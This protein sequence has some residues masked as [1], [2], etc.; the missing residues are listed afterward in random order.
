MVC[1]HA[2]QEGETLALDGSPTLKD[3]ARA[4][5]VSE[6]TASR[7]L[8]LKPGTVPISPETQ[9]RVRQ[10]AS[11][12]GYRTNRLA[13]SLSRA[14]TDTLGV[15]LPFDA[16][17][18]G[19]PYNSLILA[20]VG[21]AATAR[22]FALALY[23]AGPGTRDNY[24]DAL[25]DGRVDG[26]LVV[27][28][29]VLTDA[30]VA[31]LEGERFPLILVGHRLSASRVS[32]V[33]ADD[34]GA[35]AALT[36]HLIELGHRRIVHLY[37]A[38]GHPTQQRRLG[39]VDAMV[40]AGLLRDDSVVEDTVG[41]NPDRLDHGEL[42]RALLDRPE[43]PTAIFAWNDVV[44]ASVLQCA[45]ELGV[46]V[47]RRLSVVGFNDTIV[48]QLTSPPLTTMHQPLFE[49]GQ[50]AANALVDQIEARR[51]GRDEAPIQRILPG[52]IIARASCAPPGETT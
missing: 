10:V 19:K 42:V 23:Y 24:A 38:G 46:A 21:Q 31:R 50:E 12:I 26:G 2:C 9:A 29:T 17:T 44:A 41:D 16:E 15:L 30:Q 8:H 34:R 36:R 5:G 48:A 45:S 28:S 51:A 52:R 33:A 1:H 3:I 47:P 20:G 13:R 25:R 7:V 37:F 39:F 18:L 40:E 32:F 6:A 49:M 11:Q 22:G 43:P 14:H 4:A 27:D 35:G